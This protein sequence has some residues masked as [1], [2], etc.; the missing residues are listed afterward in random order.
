MP[1]PIT[2]LWRVSGGMR[3]TEGV[4]ES[5]EVARA[6][7]S[8]N[9]SAGFGTAKLERLHIA[10]MTMVRVVNAALQLDAMRLGN[11][12]PDVPVWDWFILK[13]LEYQRAVDEHIAAT[14]A[15][16]PALDAARAAGGAH[17]A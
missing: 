6:Q 1:E 9:L 15:L 16:R 8:L 5:E 10:S 11:C 17:D 3:A 14:R 4:Y 7:H 2:E 12:P 13:H